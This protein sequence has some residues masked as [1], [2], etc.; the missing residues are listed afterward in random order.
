[1]KLKDYP[2]IEEELLES[3]TLLDTSSSEGKLV[4]VSEFTDEIALNQIFQRAELLVKRGAIDEAYQWYKEAT[5]RF[6]ENPIA[7]RSKGDFEYR[8]FEEK[9]AEESFSKAIS[10]NPRDPFSYNSWAYWKFEMGARNSSKLNFKMSI[11]LN[12]K[13]LDLSE[14]NEDIRRMKDFIA[15]AYMKLGYITRIEAFNRRSMKRKEILN[16]KDEYLKKAIDILERN[17]IETPLNPP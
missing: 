5:E 2:E 9:N 13:A 12:E 8:Y 17:L 14:K 6:P 11:E 10:L 3:T 1:M 15:S 7:W 16:E 4:G